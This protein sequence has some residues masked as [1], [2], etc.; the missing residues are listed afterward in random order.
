MRR[1]FGLCHVKSHYV[2]IAPWTFQ[3]S[4]NA[5]GDPYTDL[6]TSRGRPEVMVAYPG[7]EG[8]ILTPEYEAVREGV[9]DGKYAYVL[10][11]RIEN[12]KN[13]GDTGLQDLGRQAEAA[14]EEILQSIENA[15]LEKMDA[16]RATMVNWILRIPAL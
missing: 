8:P 9:D 15:S 11:T 10:E 3:T 4:Q 14:Y 5:N 1:A 7:T 2:G 12:A 16:N 13:S 6:D